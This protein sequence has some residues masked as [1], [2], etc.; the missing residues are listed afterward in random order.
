MQHNDL[1]LA[2]ARHAVLLHDFGDCKEMS[3]IRLFFWIETNTRVPFPRS[4]ATKC[5]GF[6][7]WTRN[8][9][10]DDLAMRGADG[11]DCGIRTES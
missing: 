1:Q 4:W 3:P 11:R 5:L 9:L 8:V 10:I 2:W 6:Q 7:L